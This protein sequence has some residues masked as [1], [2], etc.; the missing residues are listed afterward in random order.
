MTDPRNPSLIRS[1]S[2]DK[3]GMQKT[4]QRLVVGDF[5]FSLYT[6]ECPETQ[7][8]IHHHWRHTGACS[9]IPAH[10]LIV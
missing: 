2:Q 5:A 3:N 10:P 9:H 6:S 8:L 4:Q 1:H 7:E